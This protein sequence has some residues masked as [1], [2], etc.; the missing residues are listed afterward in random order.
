MSTT[1]TWRDILRE[2]H[3]Q[4]T[5][6]LL[7]GAMLAPVV[8]VVAGW[9]V[10]TPLRVPLAVHA[11]ALAAVGLVAFGLADR[12][13]IWLSRRRRAGW[14]LMPAFAVSFAIILEERANAFYTER[15]LVDGTALLFTLHL[16]AGL[17]RR[18]ALRRH[19]PCVAER[20]PDGWWQRGPEWRRR[21]HARCLP[22][23]P[24]LRIADALITAAGWLVLAA[25]ALIA[26]E[27]RHPAGPLLLA[28]GALEALALLALVPDAL[29][30]WGWLGPPAPD[31]PPRA[32]RRH[33]G[34]GDE[35][36]APFVADSFR[37]HS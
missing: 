13:A 28:A 12:D 32:R 5:S 33:R 30:G 23:T 16:A 20:A 18:R 2:T 34:K 9:P 37:G 1:P 35:P 6:L 7:V 25:W 10:H 21:V 24:A 8:G 36:R 26:L 22:G 27:H 4:L 17:L 3:R 29:A 19:D 15:L 14:L 31:R 11:A